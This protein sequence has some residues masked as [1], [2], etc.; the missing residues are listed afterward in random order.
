MISNLFRTVVVL[1]RGLGTH[2]AASVLTLGL[3][4]V[5][6]AAALTATLML[7]GFG[8][9]LPMVSWVWCLRRVTANPQR[10]EAPAAL[11][12]YWVPAAQVIATRLGSGPDGLSEEEAGRRLR[13]G[14]PNR[15]RNRGTRSRLE[16]VWAQIRNPLLLILVFAACA[17]ALS[18]EWIDAA[19]V[20]VIV[21][22]SVG[23]G[24][25]RDTARRRL[26]PPCRHR[27]SAYDGCP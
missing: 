2:E 10:P 24:Y 14:G 4:G 20:V 8:I 22:A 16:V 23:I 26:S 9:W 5:S 21:V 7:G 18:G 12:A 17:S 25:A 1:A 27:C 15:L 6:D 19:I 11:D 13:S 3:G